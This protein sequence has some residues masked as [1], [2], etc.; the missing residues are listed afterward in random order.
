MQMPGIVDQA[1][2]M[3]QHSKRISEFEDQNHDVISINCVHVTCTGAGLV[4]LLCLASKKWEIVNSEI[5]LQG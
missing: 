4:K 3:K 2:M 5:R 1:E